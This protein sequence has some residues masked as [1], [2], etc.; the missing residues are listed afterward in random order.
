MKGGGGDQESSVA[1]EESHAFTQVN[2]VFKAF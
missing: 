2:D 1:L